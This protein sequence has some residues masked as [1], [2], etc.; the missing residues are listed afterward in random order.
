MKRVAVMFGGVSCEHDI[1]IIT[2]VQLMNNIGRTEYD[3]V[4][5]YID[6]DSRW[7]TGSTLFDL[8]NY[9]VNL[10]K[11]KECVILP[12]DNKLY[13]KKGSR[14]VSSN[15]IDIAILCFHGGLGEGGAISGM[16]E[17][18]G[19]PYTSTDISSSAICLDKVLFKYVMNGLGI[20]TVDGLDLFENEYILNKELVKS[21]IS[22]LGYPVIIKPARLGSSIGITI[23]EAEGDIEDKLREAFRYDSRVLIEKYIDIAKEINIAIFENKGDLVLSNTEEPISKDKIL[24][25]EEKYINNPG[26]F[27][28]IKR[29]SPANIDKD[30]EDRIKYMAT[31]IY[32]KL[33]LFGVVRFD[34]IIDK[35]GVIYIN[36]VNTIPGS[37]ANYLYDKDLMGY[38]NLIDALISNAIHRKYESQKLIKYFNNDVLSSGAK[39]LEK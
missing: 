30:I 21:K 39:V 28:T 24:S 11:L 33:D 25:F 31:T 16:M 10:G 18:S 3:I 29:I 13:I 17:M 26:G 35:S 32:T 1:S 2:A 12:N 37:M 9:N 22:E 23:S 15:I 6:K 4:P 36:E 8:D 19:I 5:I 20:R 7:L 27:E 38:P 14:Y 34:F